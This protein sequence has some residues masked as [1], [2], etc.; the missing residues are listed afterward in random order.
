MTSCDS[1]VVSFEIFVEP[2]DR[3]FF[4][5]IQISY[6]NGKLIATEPRDYVGTAEGAIEYGRGVD[7]CIVA[8]VVSKLVVDLLHTI[9]IDEEQEQAFFLPAREIEVRRCLFEQATAIE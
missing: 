1:R 2:A 8:F 6:E 9:E 3:V 5:G 7:E 4:A